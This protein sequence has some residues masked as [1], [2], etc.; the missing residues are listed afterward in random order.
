MHAPPRAGQ[1]SCKE[2]PHAITRSRPRRSQNP[3]LQASNREMAPLSGSYSPN[4]ASHGGITS[5]GGPT[6]RQAPM[7]AQVV[8]PTRCTRPTRQRVP[9]HAEH[10]LARARHTL[11]TRSARQVSWAGPDPNRTELGLDLNCLQKKKE[12]KRGKIAGKMQN[13]QNSFEDPGKSNFALKNFK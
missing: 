2:A 3:L 11:G 5:I 8:P 12:K 10:T 13:F 9:A 4:L 7:A 6:C 1:S